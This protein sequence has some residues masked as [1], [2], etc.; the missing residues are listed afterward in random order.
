MLS[1]SSCEGFAICVYDSLR[2]RQPP[3]DSPF[4]TQFPTYLSCFHY[5]LQHFYHIFVLKNEWVSPSNYRFSGPLPL[6]VSLQLPQLLTSPSSYNPEQKSPEL[7]WK[8]KVQ[9]SLSKSLVYPKAQSAGLV[10]PELQLQA[11]LTASR[12]E[13]TVFQIFQAIQKMRSTRNFSRLFPH[14]IVV[15]SQTKADS[16]LGLS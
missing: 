13:N 1:F 8:E 16:F 15:L 5:S 6:N 11:C 12:K 7:N 3:C 14:T 10:C 4:T 9:S 2:N